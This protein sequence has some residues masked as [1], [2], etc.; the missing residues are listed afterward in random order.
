MIDPVPDLSDGVVLHRLERHAD[1]R[2]V[3]SEVY[4]QAWPSAPS[5]A[6]INLVL[7]QADAF[8]GLHVHLD[9]DDWLTV[10]SGRVLFGHLDVR[11]GSPT[12][13]RSGLI[14]LDAEVPTSIHIP[15]G[16]AHGFYTA[17][18][19]TYIYGLSR[20]WEAGQSLII[21]W[22]DPA[23]GLG[24][25]CVAPKLSAQDA[26]GRPLRELRDAFAKA[27]PVAA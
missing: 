3:L 22:R 1:E 21:D 16:V 9:N 15:S 5:L 19:A 24:W 8:R 7:S 23:T 11:P 13:G 27:F 6:Q 20:A 10:L 17:E 14:T 4:R 25:P 2:G 12:F 26:G 18:P